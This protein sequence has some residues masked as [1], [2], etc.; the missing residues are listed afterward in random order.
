MNKPA[1]THHPAGD[2]AR[3][4][5]SGQSSA[6]A[7]CEQY[8]RSIKQH[9]PQLNCFTAILEDRALDRAARVDA[10]IA[11]GECPGP[12][13]GVPFAVKNL[14]D[15]KGLPTLAGSK[16]NRE[17][18]QATVDTVL[19]QRLET[20]GAIL[21]GSLNMGEYAYDFTGENA[22]DGA[23]RNPHDRSRMSGGSSSGSGCA[24]AAGLVP[25]ALGSDTNGS[26]RVPASLCG[27]FGLKPTYGRL[28]RTGCY[29][30]S[31]SLDHVGP[32]AGSATDLAL[33][34]DALQGWDDGDPACAKRPPEPVFPSM[35]MGTAGLRIARAGGYFDC[36]DFPVAEAAVRAVCSA[37][38]VTAELPVAGAEHG[39]AAAYLITNAEGAAL[40]RARLR[41]RPEDFD[42]DTRDRFLAGAL[43]PAAW[44]LRAQ[45]VRRWWQMQMQQLFTEVDLLIAP[46]TPC[47]APLLGSK[48]L[49]V[50]GENQLLRPNLG[51]FTQPFSCIG[52]PVVSAPLWPDPAGLPIGVQ[53]VAAPWREDLCLRAALVLEQ[54]G[55]A[56]A[57]PPDSSA[58]KLSNQPTTNP[59]TESR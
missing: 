44:Y 7:L 36:S 33:C 1:G 39:R 40:H 5:A 31:D 27:V 11:A 26:I 18:A 23:C 46:C 15:I 2:I 57:S 56:R 8:L 3:Q 34:Y 38:Q 50:R 30:F 49:W 47:T 12:L 51:L 25:L 17:R 20:A 24:I 22:H 28:P 48:T 53:I 54:C 41:T 55:L 43:M 14:F 13:A 52:L 32:L 29:P 16:I 21:V 9:N 45:A 10:D 59:T 35:G 37:L 19:I 42:P 58:I 4:V 6:T